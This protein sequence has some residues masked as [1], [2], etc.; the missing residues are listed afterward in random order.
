[1]TEIR[2]SV[3]RP[4]Q[5]FRDL[6]EGTNADLVPLVSDP[7]HY[8][9]TPSTPPTIATPTVPAR[10]QDLITAAYTIPSAKTL[11]FGTLNTGGGEF[12][13]EFNA[14]ATLTNAGTI[15]SLP[16][17]GGGA[18]FFDAIGAVTGSVISNTASGVISLEAPSY[19][20][21]AVGIDT[22]GA[23]VNAGVIQV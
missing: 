8:I 16:R 15:V 11:Y 14:K 2:H 3:A 23:V 19:F 17:Y 10:Q 12:S 6:G 4:G 13:I 20:G 5:L 18:V 21:N 7:G 1:M 9:G 22:T